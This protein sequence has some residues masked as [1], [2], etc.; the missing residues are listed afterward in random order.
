MIPE[1]E[2]QDLAIESHP[3]EPRKTSLLSLLRRWRKR[4]IWTT[5]LTPLLAVLLSNAWLF[6][7]WGRSYVARKISARTGVEAT[8]SGAWW[9]PGGQVKIFDIVLLQPPAL[10]ATLS[11]PLA[12]VKCLTLQ[13]HWKQLLRGKR[14]FFSCQVDAPDIVVTIE[15]LQQL[16]AAKSPSFIQSAPPPDGSPPPPTPP[17]DIAQNPSPSTPP[18][19]PT[20]QPAPEAP[21]VADAPAPVPLP[22]SWFYLRNAR[23]RLIHAGSGKSLLDLRDLTMDV[24][25]EGPQATGRF[26]FSS[27]EAL[28]QPLFDKTE[29]PLAWKPPVLHIGSTTLDVA[30]LPLRCEVQIAKEAGMPFQ[31]MIQ[32]DPI[33]WQAGSLFQSAKVQSLHRA[34]GF[35]LAPSSWRGESILFAQTPRL[36]L[37]SM[38]KDFQLLQAH[39]ILVG[40]ALQCSDFRL[41]GDEISLL[42][43]GA[44]LADTQ[45]L[46][47]LRVVA[48][49]RDAAFV[50]TMLSRINPDIPQRLPPFGNEDRRGA[51]FLFG[52]SLFHTWLS[53]DG[54]QTLLDVRK[55]YNLI[56]E[57]TRRSFF[58][59]PPPKR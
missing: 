9:I 28:G 32:Q 21:P 17:A 30:G 29:I 44:I 2:S 51:D 58:P 7:P 33:A 13:P 18:V 34:G 6:S 37:G 53:L 41:V 26:A 16:L 45:L 48:S 43:N 55:I 40:G 56:P 19:A 14:D 31:A 57:E 49:P 25:V 23:I 52:G 35:L 47:V 8:V 11:E 20:P 39:I 10:R 27:L 15:M 1:A 46:S 50:E 42:G 24:P 36:S 54:G 5:L 59:I 38:S 12:T 3:P 4:L 22:E